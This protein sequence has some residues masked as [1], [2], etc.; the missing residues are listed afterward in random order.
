[1]VGEVTGRTV[2]GRGGGAA[3]SLQELLEADRPAVAPGRD[4]AGRGPSITDPV[5]LFRDLETSGRFHR[6]TGFGRIFHAGHVSFRENLPTDSL[7]VLVDGDRLA[8][9]VDRVSPL[10]LRP[11]RPVRYSVRRTLTHN[12]VGAAE[13][14]I[15]LARGRQGDHRSELDCEWSWGPSDATPGSTGLL[16]RRASAWSVQMEAG[17]SGRLDEARLRRALAGVLGRRPLDHDPLWSVDCPDGASVDAARERLQSR[18]AAITQ[19]PPLRAALAR[20]PDG[21]VLM[22]NVTHAAS[23]GFDALRLLRTIAGAYATGTVPEPLPDFVALADLPVRP[24]SAPVSGVSARYRAAVERLRDLLA[25]PALLAADEDCADPAFGFHLVCLSADETSK[26]VDPDRPG[27]SRNMVL[28][29]LHLAIGEWNLRHGTPGRRVGVLV[30]VNLRAPEWPEE[31]VGNFSVTARISTSRRHRSGAAAALEAVT[32]QTTRNKQSRTGVA[33]LAA[34]E[35]S[36]ML[37]LWCKQSL[38]VLMPLV[39]NRSVDT[40][41]LAN[42][43]V[44]DESPSFGD[45]AGETVDLWFSS[46]ARGPLTLCV[47]AVTVGGRLHLVLRYPRRLFSAGAARRFADCL[48]SEL[49]GVAAHRA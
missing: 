37:A 48:V 22:L 10:G 44:L 31:A 32:A 43:G 9:H 4:G 3:P 21:D 5:E 19:W 17:V 46:P 8:A 27:T 45:D 11:R 36:G 12:V 33:L 6:D 2:E 47:G 30:P 18:P 13:D 40:A 41:L 1:V 14:L 7:H 25:N 20:C 49:A 42:L 26:V 35:R 34:L 38:I 23:D 39:R 16:D 28:A 15:R 24:A 29:G